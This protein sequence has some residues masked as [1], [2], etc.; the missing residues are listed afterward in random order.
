[1]ERR[2]AAPRFHLFVCSNERPATDPLGEGCGARGA[3]VFAALK[4]EV[5]SARAY[6]TVWV[7][8]THCLGICPK[9]GC[10]VAKWGTGTEGEIVSGVD[11]PRARELVRSLL[12]LPS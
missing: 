7:T 12:R 1:M 5:A 9:E 3:K 6:G 8:R 10:T 4:E 2:H 11:E